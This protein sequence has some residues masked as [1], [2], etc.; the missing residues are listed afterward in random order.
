MKAKIAALGGD[1]IGPEVVA[2]AVRVLEATA[3]LF[4]HE[5]TITPLDF[6][7]VAIDAHG[8][9][10][11]P[12]TLRGCLESDGVLLGAIGGPKWGPTAPV[13]PE[14]ALLRLR[15]ELGV[16]ANLRPV[17]VLGALRDASVLKPEIVEGVDL[18]FVRELTGGIYFGRKQRSD[19]RATDEC[20]YTVA[21]VERITRVAG[22]LASARRRRIVQIDKSNVLETSRLWREVSERVIKTEFPGVSIEHMFVDAAAM[23][24][25]R[26]PRDFDVLLTEN[27]FGDILTDEAAMLAGSL[28]VL[29]SASLGEGRRGLYEPI[30]GSAPDI[31]GR[32]IA[33]PCGTILSAALLLRHSLGL[34]AEAAAIEAA[35]EAAIAAGARTADIA[36]TGGAS[37]G[38]IAMGDAVLAQLRRR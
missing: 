1:G 3:R 38:T 9:G 6:G 4:D 21:E 25:I 36:A 23:H 11:P 13:R 30:H 24:L 33:N 35:V 7:G 31:A 10:L 29:P 27:L 34:E 28:G 8:D 2:Q 20:A 5:F 18:L 14:P 16:Y 26:R 15:S 37:V 19:D 12:Q 22:R 17:K 32:G